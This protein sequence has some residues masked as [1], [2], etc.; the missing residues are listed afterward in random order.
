MTNEEIK[1]LT[2]EEVEERRAALEVEIKTAEPEVA[3]AI[4]AE[5]DQL[6]ER[7]RILDLEI[8]EQRKAA[9]AVAAGAGKEIETRKEDKKMTS[10]EVRNS[11]EY[12]EAFAKYIKTGNDKECRTILTENAPADNVSEFD[13]IVPVPAFVENRVRANWE[14]DKIFARARK[15]YL[16]GNL[17]VGFE[18]SS[19]GAEI[20]PEGSGSIP[21]ESLILGIVTMVPQMIK[22]W[23]SVSD[24][25]LSLGAEAF[26]TYIYDEL[27]YQIVKK[28][29][30]EI[31]NA[32]TSAPGTPDSTHVAV[33]Q[34]SGPVDAAAI[35]NAI[36]KL[37]DGAQDLVF[38][39]SG[40]T[41]ADVKIAALTA[42]FAYDPFQGLTVI[43]K[44][45][46]TG[47]IVGD[48]AGVQVNLP[49]GE[50]VRFKFDDLSMAEQDMVKIVGRLY[51]A[52]A[53]TG[54]GMF[55]YIDG[56]S[57]S[58]SAS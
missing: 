20:H 25:V 44:E 22:K 13:G 42:N 19:T 55:A 2:F 31:I 50:A 41:I 43:Q 39:A 48:L 5:F 53:V 4:N 1:T 7:K 47:A 16:K 29:A 21:D 45:G 34:V 40:Q 46:I 12:I 17:K 57:A 30:D 24:E 27:A 28:A 56:E 18:V 6:E 8:E 32:I 37:G 9:E 52:I 23:I 15:T 35:I 33:A 54:P 3:E 49:D 51:A 36:A 38:I 14:N 26:L 58:G 11:K 10:L